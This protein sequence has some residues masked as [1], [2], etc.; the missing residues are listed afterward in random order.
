MSGRRGVTAAKNNTGTKLLFK[1]NNIN[2]DDAEKINKTL[3]TIDII[4][5]HPDV[6]NNIRTLPNGTR[7][8][9]TPYKNGGKTKNKK[10]KTKNKKQKTKKNQKTLN[11]NKQPHHGFTRINPSCPHKQTPPSQVTNHFPTSFQKLF[12]CQDFQNTILEFV[13]NPHCN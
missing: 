8:A 10:Q 1:G 9:I 12:I 5:K 2:T 3:D 6:L 4:K 7:Y 13:I 11:P